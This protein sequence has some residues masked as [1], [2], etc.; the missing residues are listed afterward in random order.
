[1][2]ALSIC[3]L[4]PVLIAFVVPAVAVKPFYDEFKKDYLDS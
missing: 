2:R 1:M 3:W 4:F